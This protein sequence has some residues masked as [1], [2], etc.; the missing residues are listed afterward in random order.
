MTMNKNVKSYI[1]FEADY[2]DEAVWDNNGIMIVPD[3]RS[4]VAAIASILKENGYR[5]SDIFQHSFYGWAVDVNGPEG[6]FWCM[7]QNGEPWLLLIV[8]GKRSIWS[9]LWGLQSK[10]NDN[11]K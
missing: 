3:G 5:T 8:K 9:W 1:T 11:L 4:V 6:N 2:P 7:A 10:K